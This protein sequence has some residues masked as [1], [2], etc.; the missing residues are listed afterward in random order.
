[1]KFS[2]IANELGYIQCWRHRKN[3]GWAIVAN[4]LTVSGVVKF[5]EK[6]R[7]IERD[8]RK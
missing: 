1:V 2:F 7:G 6:K 8:E 5:R 4:V 3:A